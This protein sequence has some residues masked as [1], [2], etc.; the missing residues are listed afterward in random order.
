MG[1]FYIIIGRGVIQSGNLPAVSWR[2]TE[3]WRKIVSFYKTLKKRRRL[4]KK[5]ENVE[6]SRKRGY[7][8]K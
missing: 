4:V 2:S 1:V 5:E 6:Y 3:K 7:N 8:Q